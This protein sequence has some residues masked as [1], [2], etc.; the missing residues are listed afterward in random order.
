MVLTLDW[1]DKMLKHLTPLNI[2][3]FMITWLFIQYAI[4]S[5]PAENSGWE[6]YFGITLPDWVDVVSR[7]ILCVFAP[8][9]I[10]SSNKKEK[11]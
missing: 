11:L 1:R 6:V 5:Y 7:L 9:I 8:F 3:K 10:F 2:M 4:G